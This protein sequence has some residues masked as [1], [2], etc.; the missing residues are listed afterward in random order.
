MEQTS[1]QIRAAAIAAV[2]QMSE[3]WKSTIVARGQLNEFSGGLISPG[4]AANNDSSGIGISGGFKLGRRMVY[5]VQS[6]IDWLI[7]Q[8]K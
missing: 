8:I 6:V 2:Q 5:P 3:K 7:A 4:T 1:D